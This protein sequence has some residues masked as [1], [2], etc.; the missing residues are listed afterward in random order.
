MRHSMHATQA[1][2]KATLPVTSIVWTTDM[3]RLLLPELA[4]GRPRLENARPPPCCQH[5]S[6]WL[7][8]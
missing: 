7:Y 4:K 5:Y 6:L 8:V 3:R 2:A 1:Y